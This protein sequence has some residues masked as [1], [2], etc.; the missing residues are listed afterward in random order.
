[1][2]DA[3]EWMEAFRDIFDAANIEEILR[4]AEGDQYVNNTTSHKRLR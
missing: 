3:V 4:H 1:M 2:D